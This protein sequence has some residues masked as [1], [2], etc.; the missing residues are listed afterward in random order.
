MTALINKLIEEVQEYHEEN[1]EWPDEMRVSP[2]VH[3][4][5]Q[6]EM[7]D[8]T[9]QLNGDDEVNAKL[10]VSGAELEEDDDL[11]AVEL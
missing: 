2:L 8:A 4:L 10:V 11:T 6:T 3:D 7:E 5:V 1:D 9:T